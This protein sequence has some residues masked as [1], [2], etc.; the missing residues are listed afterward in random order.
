VLTKLNYLKIIVLSPGQTQNSEIARPVNTS[1]KHI[2]KILP[3]RRT[4]HKFN[5]L[6]LRKNLSD[7]DSD[8]L[9]TH[10]I[11]QRAGQSFD[12]IVPCPRCTVD[13]HPIC[14]TSKTGNH[15]FPNYCHLLLAN[16]DLKETRKK[17]I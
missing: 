11:G 10:I 5:L 7:T 16:C 17:N 12:N 2:L 14:A 6:E 13:Y 9:R 1:Q 4:F 15:T 3:T 8:S